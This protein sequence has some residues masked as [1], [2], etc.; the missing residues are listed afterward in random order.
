MAAA[1]TCINVTQHTED[2]GC[3]AGVGFQRPPAASPPTPAA[4]PS[5]PVAAPAWPGRELG[6]SSPLDEFCSEG[7]GDRQGTQ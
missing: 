1:N 5:P 3:Q 2:H 6:C 4:P 7:N